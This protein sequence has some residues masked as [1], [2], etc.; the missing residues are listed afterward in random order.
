MQLQNIFAA[1]SR[2]IPWN[3]WSA[4]IQELGDESRWADLPRI[5]ASHSQ[6]LSLPE[7]LGELAELEAALQ[8]CQDQHLDLPSRLTQKKLNPTLQ[9]LQLNWQGLTRFI[10]RTQDEDGYEPQSGPETVL[11][12]FD[13]RKGKARAKAATEQNLLALKLV[14]E[15]LDLGQVALEHQVNLANLH[16]SID[17]ARNQGLILGPESQLGRDVEVFQPHDKSFERFLKPKV[18]TLQWHITQACDLHCKH[19]YDRSS[20]KHMPME[21]ALLV[22]DE[23]ERFCQTYQVRAKV[24]FT[25]GNPLMYPQ[26]DELYLETVKRGFPVNILGNPTSR[27]RLEELAA[28]QKPGFYQLSLEG[29]PEHNDFVRQPGYFDRVL[30]FLP[31]LKELGISSQVMLTLTKDNM[32]Q[33]LPLGE[34]LKDQADIFTFNRLSAVGSG[35][36]LLMPSPEDYQTFL[37][38]YLAET[39]TNPV[40]GL[41]DNLINIIREEKG[42][43]PFG[44][45]TGFGCGA[46]FNFLTLLCDGEVHA[47]R[48]FPSYLGNIF[49]QGLTQVYASRAGQKYR[50]GSSACQGCKLLPACG[51]CQAVVYS[52]GLDPATDRDPYCFYAQAP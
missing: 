9:V 18:F 38:E 20:R 41:K 5:I 10:N 6:A 32:H 15:N 40:L 35:A 11:V 28:I 16:K 30:E 44:G 34:I 26:F 13:P 52:L 17:Q 24:T 47:C 19:C 12:W 25:G 27:N 22:L 29:L 42:V 49:Q 4:L 23:L 45:C 3:K 43:K 1:S 37:R 50:A 36:D 39:K 7:Y 8:T 46:G 31:I 33:V 2:W 21:K 14:A 48:K 51:G